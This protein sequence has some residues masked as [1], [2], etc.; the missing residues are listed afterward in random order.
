MVK[1]KRDKLPHTIALQVRAIAEIK[2]PKS[3]SVTSASSL[4]VDVIRYSDIEVGKKLASGSFCFIFEI[5]SVKKH[6][7]NDIVIKKLIPEIEEDPHIFAGYAADLMCEGKFL[8]ALNHPNIIRLHSWSAQDMVTDY[9]NGSRDAA[10]LVLDRVDETLDDRLAKWKSKSPKSWHLPTMR[11]KQESKLLQDECD[12]I[13]ALAKGLEYLDRN[14]ILHR[15]LKP[16]NIG[17]TSEGKLKVLDFVGAVE[18]PYS[19]DPDTLFRLT[20]KIGVPRY[21]APEVGSK[22]TVHRL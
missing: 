17:Y 11:K 7:R 8:S 9:I 16:G 3:S 10:Y 13:L 4:S 19:V 18:V 6:K 15:A 5:H 14:R 21:M 20:K 22:Y 2:S 12:T 1:S